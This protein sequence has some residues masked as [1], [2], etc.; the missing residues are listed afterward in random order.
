MS[1]F[2]IADY[3]YENEHKGY[4]VYFQDKQDQILGKFLSVLSNPYSIKEID[5]ILKIIAFIYAN[6]SNDNFEIKLDKEF[7]CDFWEDEES[8]YDKGL[9]YGQRV[10]K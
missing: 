2:V 9:R 10:R 1:K 8:E 7:G 4:Y 3:R 5:R 6:K